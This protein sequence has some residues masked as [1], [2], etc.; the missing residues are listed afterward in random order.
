MLGLAVG[1]LM[2]AKWSGQLDWSWW[3]VL[4]PVLIPAGLLTVS[5]LVL[6]AISLIE[7]D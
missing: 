5:V 4:L 2:A 3:V 7:K 1:M 6:A